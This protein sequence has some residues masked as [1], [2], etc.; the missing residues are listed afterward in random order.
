MIFLDIELEP[1]HEVQVALENYSRMKSFVKEKGELYCLPQGDPLDETSKQQ[2]REVF[3][4]DYEWS[5]KV[6][7]PSLYNTLTLHSHF[8]L[9]SSLFRDQYRLIHLL[10]S[11]LVDLSLNCMK[12]L[13]QRRVKISSAS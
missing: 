9:Y 3:Q 5:Q 11:P 8:T 12:R 6:S 1:D 13:H 2:I 7:F 4:S 10:A